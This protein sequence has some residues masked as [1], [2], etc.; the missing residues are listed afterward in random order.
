MVRPKLL[1]AAEK[2]SIS[3]SISCSLLASRVQSSAI[4]EKVSENSLLHLRDDL[5]S[6]RVKQLSVSLNLMLVP[7]SHSLKA[8]VSI[9]E[10]NMLNSVGARTQP[11]LNS[12]GYWEG[13]GGFAVFQDSS[14]HAIMDLADYC[15][16]RAWAA[17]FFHDFP[18]SLP[19][20]CIEGLGQVNEGRVEVMVLFHAFLLE[21][22][23]T[24]FKMKVTKKVKVTYS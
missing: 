21:L 24:A 18:E 1:Q 4:E 12:V 15:D 5:Q 13:F 16:E 23:G 3:T 17:E 10:N 11:C 9:A 7:G 19:T 2:L 22:V 8:S 14:H 6:P 20:D